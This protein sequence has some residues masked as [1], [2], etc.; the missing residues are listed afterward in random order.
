MQQQTQTQA[1]VLF[2]IGKPLR[3]IE[4]G[5]PAL[6]AGQVLVD[7]AYS[8][9]CHSQLNEV[10]GHK[11]PDRYVPHTLG[12]E[13][14]GTVVAVAGGV[15]KVK[16]G[17]RVVLSWL[18]GSGADVPGTIY[19]SPEGPINSGAISTFMRRTITCENRVTA[20]PDAMP[21]RLAAL[22]G[23]AIPTGAG[24]VFNTSGLAPGDSIAIF[25]VGGI[26]LSAVMAAAAVGAAPIVAVDIVPEKLDKARELGATHTVNAGEVDPVSA[27]RS[28]T[29]GK[30]VRVAVECAGRVVA[31]EAA[32]ESVMGGGGLC[33][34]AGNPP[35]GQTMRID[36]FGLIGGKRV[37]GTWGGETRPDADIP[38][39][40][41]MFLSG[42]LAL[43]KLATVEYP[44]EE[45]NAALDDLEA[46]RII[47][48][49]IPMGGEA[50]S[51]R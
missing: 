41:E 16:P 32:F 7:V 31:M 36:P 50:K 38:R 33:V 49:M 26:G 18:K 35:H 28:I 22:L 13:G 10:R 11:G 2:E 40:V 21:L 39:Y 25:G 44:I 48:A 20:I 24:V 46:G 51:L 14:A 34:I 45:I 27:I 47:R 8:G 43:Q 19:E 30:G 5:I 15:A 17:D 12:H 37:I 6:K 42:R 9:V 23:C 4:V 29:G 1:A 3:L